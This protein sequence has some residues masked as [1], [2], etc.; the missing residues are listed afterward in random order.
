MSSNP[1]PSAPI[2]INR[3]RSPSVDSDVPGLSLGSTAPQS[4]LQVSDLLSF[5]L[6]SHR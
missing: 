4:P 5:L 1:P 2:P 6:H 3:E